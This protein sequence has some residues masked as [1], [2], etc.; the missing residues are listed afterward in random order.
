MIFEGQPLTEGME[1]FPLTR[2]DIV[3]TNLVQND[4][5]QLEVICGRCGGA[6][7]VKSDHFPTPLTFSPCF[8]TNGFIGF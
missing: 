7:T 1:P 2:C 5:G 3:C 4:L 6:V 8:W